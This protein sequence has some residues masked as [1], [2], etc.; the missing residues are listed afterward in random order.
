MISKEHF[1]LHRSEKNTEMV[2]LTDNGLT[3][4]TG[5]TNTNTLRCSFVCVLQRWEVFFLPV[6]VADLC[7]F[8]LQ[9][10]VQLIVTCSV[11]Y[12]KIGLKFGGKKRVAVLQ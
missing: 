11:F 2:A 6:K 1:N 5:F 12:S 8:S 10:R 3:S 7:N 4:L 9:S